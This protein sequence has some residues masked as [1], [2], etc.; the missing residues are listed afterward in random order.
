VLACLGTLLPGFAV[1]MANDR[2]PKKREPVNRF[3]ARPDR[4]LE[5]KPHRV[6]DE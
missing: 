2:P 4:L 3:D 5:A 1:V 6:I